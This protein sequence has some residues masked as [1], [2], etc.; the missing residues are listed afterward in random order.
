M[1][2]SKQDF[3][4]PSSSQKYCAKWYYGTTADGW[5]E[6]VLRGYLGDVLNGRPSTKLTSNKASLRSELILRVDYEP[7]LGLDDYESGKMEITVYQLIP[8]WFV[9]KEV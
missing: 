9:E 3:A 8:L 6:I 1:P 4:E 7:M 5:A 2:S